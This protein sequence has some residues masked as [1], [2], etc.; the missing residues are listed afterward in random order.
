[1]RLFVATALAALLTAAPAL[2]ITEPVTETARLGDV[3]AE[4][5]YVTHTSREGY[6]EPTDIT[7]KVFDG[8]TQI[9]DDAIADSEAIRPSYL[10]ED[11]DSVRVVDLDGDGVGEAMFDFYRPERGYDTPVYQGATR[12][13]LFIGNVYYRLM[14]YDG[15]GGP[16][17]STFDDA[18]TERYASVSAQPIRVLKLGDGEF[19][20]FTT[21]RSV[22]PAIKEE[23]GKFERYLRRSR[24]A[25]DE[26]PADR[27]LV[28][29]ALAGLAADYCSLG[30][31][32]KGYALV[33]KL[34]ATGETGRAFK[35]RLRTDLKKLGYALPRA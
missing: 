11:R 35:R 32:A 28:K 16:E 14:D 4:L 21:D 31:C 6:Y 30:N 2:A 3:R 13:D 5:S 12:V 29:A 27:Q 25:A 8:G 15:Q 23:I 19:E 17:I 24:R 26:D 20:N 34:I 1:M 22:A 7:M 18:F 9:V 33:D 10:M